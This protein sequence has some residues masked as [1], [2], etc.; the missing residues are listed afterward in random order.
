MSYART[1]CMNRFKWHIRDLRE[2]ETF[3]NFLVLLSFLSHANIHE[4]FRP[5]VPVMYRWSAC[6]QREKHLFH[7]RMPKCLDLTSSN[8]IQR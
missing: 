4:W 7:L 2:L 5:V 8:V 6:L 1:A 3:T